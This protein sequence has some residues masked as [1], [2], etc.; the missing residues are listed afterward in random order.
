M[1]VLHTESSLGWGG[2]ENR[3]LNEMLGLREL[4]HT[5]LII[6]QPGA[7]LGARAREAGFPV[8]ETPM[9]S[10]IDLPAILGLRRIMA[11]VRPDVVNTHSGRDT[12]LAGMAARSLMRRPCI[13]RTRHLALP[14]T[15]RF[16]YS[17]L[18]DHVVAV[19]HHVAR[20]LASAGIPA[21]RIS[22]VHTGIDLTRYAVPAGGSTLRAELGMP[23]NAPLVGT[24]AILRRKKGHAELLEAIPAVLA[25]FPDTHFVFAG[26]GPQ[27]ANLERRIAELQLGAYVHLLGLRR[28]V[29]NVLAS[30]DLFVL[31]THQEAL[32]TAFV[33]AGAMGLAAIGSRVDGVPEVI[34]DGKTGLLVP[35]HDPPALA[36]AIIA[37]LAD[38]ARRRALGE[39]AREKVRQ[40]FSRLAMVAGM[41]DVYESLIETR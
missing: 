20:A 13:V 27:R 39:A 12:Q 18:P 3:T 21:E 7:R 10:A 32:G 11:H 6:C 19:S 15:S 14:I 41:L 28:D 36:E 35:V 33:E 37:L 2:Q 16:T 30:L 34:D 38:P 25:R 9:R 29:V 5:A 26:D 4:G 1:I 17:V 22:T 24:V 40:R 23:E 31:P 8:F